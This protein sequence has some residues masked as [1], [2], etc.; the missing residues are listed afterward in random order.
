MLAVCVVCFK[1]CWRNQRF[2]D[3]K[4]FSAPARLLQQMPHLVPLHVAIQADCLHG[5]FSRAAGFPATI[6]ELFMLL[7]KFCM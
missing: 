3:P 5:C 1:G 4:T 2:C 6:L 7:Q